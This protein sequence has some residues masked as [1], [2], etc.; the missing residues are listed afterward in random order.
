MYMYTTEKFPAANSLP[1]NAM[2]VLDNVGHSYHTEMGEEREYLTVPS[3]RSPAT[4]QE[5]PVTSRQQARKARQAAG[6]GV[7]S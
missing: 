4:V 1:S 7:V 3:S 2:V 6:P 5:T